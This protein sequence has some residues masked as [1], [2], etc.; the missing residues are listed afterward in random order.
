MDY[1]DPLRFQRVGIRS[2]LSWLSSLICDC[3]GRGLKPVVNATPGFKAETSLALLLAQLLGASVFYIHERMADRVI[4]LPSL[5]LTVT[6]EYWEKWGELVLAVGILG[7]REVQ[8]MDRAR[9]DALAGRRYDFPEVEILFDDYDGGKTL[10]AL[11]QLLYEAYRVPAGQLTAAGIDPAQKI[12]WPSEE[13]HWPRGFEQAM[14]QIAEIAFVRYIRPKRFTGAGSSGVSRVFD[15]TDRGVLI[16]RHFGGQYAAEARVETTARNRGEWEAARR[17][18]EAALLAYGNVPAQED[19]ALVLGVLEEYQ[20]VEGVVR[21]N[22]AL[23]TEAENL[24]SEQREMESR[25]KK[26]LASQKAYYKDRIQEL[27]QRLREARAATPP[28]EQR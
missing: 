18:V 24:R 9:F 1:A 26:R 21:A 14:R 7:E 2:F 23:R 19:A 12:K 27:E 13:H 3:Q 6:P 20:S 28:A 11:G 5:P 22:E 8:G 10:S 4:L 15:E 17:Q 16:C 25:C